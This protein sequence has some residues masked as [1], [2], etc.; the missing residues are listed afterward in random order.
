MV[1]DL[2]QFLL[3]SSQQRQFLNLPSPKWDLASLI[4]QSFLSDKLPGVCG[5][6]G[7]HQPRLCV[8]TC[9]MLGCEILHTNGL[10]ALQCQVTPFCGFA[11]SGV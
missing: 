1:P 7:Q 5:C 10:S 6:L 2:F 3:K 8:C 4:N 9:G 11:G